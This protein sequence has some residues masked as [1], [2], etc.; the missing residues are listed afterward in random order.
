MPGG[1]TIRHVSEP[2]KNQPAKAPAVIQPAASVILVRDGSDGLGGLEVLLLRRTA[3]ASFAPEAWVFPGGR[4][5]PGDGLDP[6]SL[7]A[8]RQGA[9]RETVEEA[10][11][12]VD[13]AALIPYAQWCPPPESPKRFLTWFFVV[14]APSVGGVTVDGG[15]ITEHEWVRPADAIAARDE[16]RVDLLPPTWM[17]LWD[18]ARRQT[19]AEVLA[20]AQEAPPPYFETHIAFLPREDD[21]S[22]QDVVALWEGDA[23]YELRDATLP[24]P[25][26]RLRMG[27]PPWVYEGSAA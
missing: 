19:V 22:K 25:R 1:P 27:E 15:E 8:A 17:T 6:L 7:E 23:G 24:G 13:P 26:H 14:A 4:I 12:I 16:G 10:G 5:D 11:V 20:A 21:P 18:L 9:A 3:K 2:A